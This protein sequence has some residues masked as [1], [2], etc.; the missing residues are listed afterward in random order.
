MCDITLILLWINNNSCEIYRHYQWT[1]VCRNSWSC[2]QGK[3][4]LLNW[5]DIRTVVFFFNIK[6]KTM[7]V[8]QKQMVHC[9]TMLLF[10]SVLNT[11]ITD[12]IAISCMLFAF[13]IGGLLYVRIPPVHKAKVSPAILNLFNIDQN[14]IKRN[15]IFHKGGGYHA[16]ENTL[17]AVQQVNGPF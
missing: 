7:L 5:D 6:L 9:G 4:S 11:F 14:N 3:I 10:W 17:E 12:S 1:A 13:L 16:P 8:S 15:L 2:L